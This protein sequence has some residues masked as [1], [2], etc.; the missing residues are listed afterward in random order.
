MWIDRAIHAVDA[1]RTA[2]DCARSGQARFPIL[3]ASSRSPKCCT[4]KEGNRLSPS[5]TVKPEM[6]QHFSYAE[7]CLHIAR[8]FE[9][10]LDEGRVTGDRCIRE[11]ERTVPRIGRMIV[12]PVMSQSAR[13]QSV[14]GYPALGEPK[15]L[16]ICERP[17]TKPPPKYCGP[18]HERSSLLRWQL[19]NLALTGSAA[20]SSESPP[21]PIAL[22]HEAAMCCR[23]G[24][25]NRFNCF[26][27]S[28]ATS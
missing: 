13:S 26:P 15:L 1:R 14:P 22:D 20:T 17:S 10:G 16:W 23:H 4:T 21:G 27:G 3:A 11:V 7:D 24:L 8:I 28:L 12:T 25:S 5:E 19:A 9:A 2:E 6:E 18:T